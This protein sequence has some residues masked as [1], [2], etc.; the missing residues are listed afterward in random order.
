VILEPDSIL[1]FLSIISFFYFAFLSIVKVVFK[2]AESYENSLQHQGTR[3]IAQKVN[4]ILEDRLFF[5]ISISVGKSVAG[6][7]LT[8]SLFT[9]LDNYLDGAV[10]F[11]STMVAITLLLSFPGYIIPKATAASASEKYLPVAYYVYNINL[12]FA[13]IVFVMS[14][15]HRI[16]LQ[17]RGFDEK[18]SFLTEQEKDRLSNS[19]DEEELLDTDERAM[20]RNIFDFGDT[21]VKEVMVPRI[22]MTALNITTDFNTVLKIV[23]EEGH[24]RIPIYENTIDSIV[25]ILYAKDILRWLLSEEGQIKPEDWDLKTIIKKASFVPANK[26]LDDLMTEMKT[27]HTHLVIV[28]D[29]YGGTEGICTLEDIL[30]EI[31]GEIRDEY[32]EDEQEMIKVDEFSYLVDPHMELDDID[33]QI[34]L[35]FDFEDKEYNTI[36]G[37]FYHE[38]GE[39]PNAGTSFEFHGHTLKIT[40]MNNQ[41]IEEILLTVP[42]TEELKT[43]IDDKF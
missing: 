35:N 18:F 37:L 26:K 19:G 32:D 22:D 42:R 4:H 3:Y 25:G 27:N 8:I 14:S 40:K 28:V 5:T 16:I 39:V 9:I 43:E 24:S 29:E 33:D 34:K 15:L 11:V 6:S 17:R 21:T 7:L 41:R 12:I 13:P 1:Y 20:I 23:T 10:L 31:V 38:Y 30:E 36:G 2:H